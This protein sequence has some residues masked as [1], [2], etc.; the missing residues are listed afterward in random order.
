MSPQVP[1][2]K[3][4]ELDLTDPKVFEAFESKVQDQITFDRSLDAFWFGKIIDSLLLQPAYLS[5]ELSFIEK[6]KR[7]VIKTRWAALNLLP[8]KEIVEMFEK[9]FAEMIDVPDYSAWLKLK[10]RLVSMLIFEERDVL[11]KNI[12]DAL[13]RNQQKITDKNIVIEEKEFSPTIA[14]W[15]KD[16][17]R[18]MGIGPLDKLKQAEYF[19]KNKNISSVDISTREKIIS[20]FNFYERARLSSLTAEG[21]EE[22]IPVPAGELADVE[23]VIRNGRF[24][25]MDMKI[26]KEMEETLNKVFPNGRV[27][28]ESLTKQEEITKSYLGTSEEQKNLEAEKEEIIKNMGGAPDKLMN[29]LYEAIALQPGKAPKKEKVLATLKILAETDNLD[30][31]LS[32]NKKFSEVLVSCLKEK[33]RT[34]EIEGFK[35]NPGAPQYLGI[36][37]Q[38]IL[39]DILEMSENDS[40]RFGMQLMNLFKEKGKDSK[41][42]GLT[43]FD[44]ATGEFR[45]D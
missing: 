10:Q 32:E 35:V 12:I 5:V 37:L 15:L 29:E 38:H 31:L 3:L 41:Y 24:E 22:T 42:F 28:V 40:A 23:G 6:Y 1:I 4:K 19:S 36:F 25:P 39:K 17:I 26:V 13:M 20:L 30:D 18:V 27:E 33:G 7:L 14:N 44:S 45:W 21:L 2:G 16:Y 9:Y 11:K 34:A 8:E 43:Y